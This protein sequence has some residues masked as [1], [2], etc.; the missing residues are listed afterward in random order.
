MFLRIYLYPSYVPRNNLTIYRERCHLLDDLQAVTNTVKIFRRFSKWVQISIQIP[1][2]TEPFKAFPRTS[3]EFPFLCLCFVIFWFLFC[4]CNTC[5]LTGLLTLTIGKIS[6]P[7]SVLFFQ[8]ISYFKCLSFTS[9]PHFYF[10]LSVYWLITWKYAQALNFTL[11]L[12]NK[13]NISK[14]FGSGV[15]RWYLY[16][17]IQM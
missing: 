1:K 10:F 13:L 16:I 5:F 4:L 3:W 11:L 8:V 7:A 2:L 9:L 6:A 14:R 15:C 12:V 17:M